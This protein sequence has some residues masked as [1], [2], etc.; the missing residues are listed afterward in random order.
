[1]GRT[2]IESWNVSMC[3]VEAEPNALPFLPEINY[4]CFNV[5]IYLRKN[6]LREWCLPR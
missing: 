3:P 6:A 5:F 2:C 1:M 4:A